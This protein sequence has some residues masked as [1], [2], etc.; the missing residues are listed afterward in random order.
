MRIRVEGGHALNGVYHP[1]G[2]T[3]AAVGLLAVSLLTD[4]PVTLANVPRN[5]STQLMLDMAIW[6]GASVALT[7]LH[8]LTLVT[9]QVARRNLTPNETQG[10][11][12]A[13]LYLAPVLVRRGYVRMEVDF[14]LNRIRTHLDAL[15][16]LGQDV[17][18]SEGAVE[19]RAARWDYRDIML[20]QASVTATEIALMLAAALGKETLI[21]NAASEPHVQQVAETLELMGAQI[22]GVGSNVLRVFGHQGGLL[23]GAQI[24]IQPDHIEAASVAALA[25]LTGGRLTVEGIQP[26]HMQMIARVYGFLGI[27][28]EIDQNALYVPRHTGLTISN[29]EE[30]VDSSIKTAPWP[31]FPSDLVAI[32]TVAA[33]QARGTSLIHETLFENRLV[34]VDKLNSMGAQIVFCDPHRAIVV[35]RT[36]LYAIYMDSP[37]VRTG[38]GLLG[39]ALVAEGTSIIDNAQAIT[40][41]FE[42]VLDKL[43]GLGAQIVVE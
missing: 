13:L 17:V 19:I 36:P 16:D 37:D 42:G 29:R 24:T 35:G 40:R 25:A 43:A 27:T 7:D 1:S 6:L 4:Q 10:F 5:A 8:T 30:D 12:G 3:N 32:A 23:H 22:E 2:N 31:G 15:R 14:P 33:T 26:A 38:L 28:L 9:E 11:V 18:F 21:R 20:T 41:S 39:A 34:F